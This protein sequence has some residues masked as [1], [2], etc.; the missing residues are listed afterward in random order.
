MATTKMLYLLL[1]LHPADWNKLLKERHLEAF[2]LDYQQIQTQLAN[3]LLALDAELHPIR[4]VDPGAA[5]LTEQ[6]FETALKLRLDQGQ[7]TIVNAPL[8]SRHILR[9]LKRISAAW[10]FTFVLVDSLADWFEANDDIEQVI[11][12]H[13][14]SRDDAKHLS[15]YRAIDW[16]AL[17][18]E[19]LTVDQFVA[20]LQQ[21]L[22]A[23]SIQASELIV[24]GDVHGDAD[25]LK[26]ILA[27]HPQAKVIL[28]G[29]YE[30]RGPQTPAVIEALLAHPQATLLSG[31]HEDKL[32]RY[33]LEDRLPK[34]EAARETIHQL[35]SS[36]L[37]ATELMT[38]LSRLETYAF[39]KFAGRQF[40]LSHAGIEPQIFAAWRSSH[41][42]QCQRLALANS[43][44]FVYG[45]IV[46]GQSVYQ[47]DVDLAWAQTSGLDAIQIHG[48]RNRF[49]RTVLRDQS[50][51]IN[52]TDADTSTLRYVV[53]DTNG[54][55]Q[56]H[57]RMRFSN[58][59]DISTGQL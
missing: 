25:D 24:I 13:Q 4:Q 33:L 46:N 10:G 53:I 37:S 39:L 1:S 2:T 29:D 22:I 36:E 6:Y 41:S 8:L 3:P 12:N 32:K 50:T 42:K 35:K 17:G 11:S 48:H 47:R 45:T 7:P 27:D 49:E 31:N 16:H 40:F 19:P 43:E 20:R 38:F 52:L 59:E 56:Y 14:L 44:T 21:P 9:A 28:L 30:D 26:Q 15:R 34:D 55:Y 54:H 23:S 51:S 58:H 18:W 5:K 57:K